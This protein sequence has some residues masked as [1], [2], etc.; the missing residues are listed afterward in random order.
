MNYTP[1]LYESLTMSSIDPTVNLITNLLTFVVLIAA[2]IGIA[3]TFHKAGE[4]WWKALIPFYCEYTEVRVGRSPV[5]WFW[6]MLSAGFVATLVLTMAFFVIMM[7]D[8]MASVGMSSFGLALAVAAIAIYVVALTFYGRILHNLAQTF[9][10]GLG[11]TLGLLF[12]SPIFWLILGLGQAQY[13]PEQSLMADPTYDPEVYQP[14]GIPVPA[15]ASA[16][17]AAHPRL[18]P[19]RVVAY[20]LLILVPLLACCLAASYWVDMMNY[21][22]LTQTT[23]YF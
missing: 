13:R 11:F 22:A 14:L 15:A 9:G 12:L 21:S 17:E 6:I 16:A 19:G 1:Y 18:S 7:G 3:L 5:S 23:P 8:G 4:A 2:S 10:K 20:I